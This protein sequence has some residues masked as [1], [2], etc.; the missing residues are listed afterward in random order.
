MMPNQSDPTPDNIGDSEPDS[1][2]ETP[3]EVAT[4]ADAMARKVKGG[5]E[6]TNESLRLLGAGD[7]YK[8]NNQ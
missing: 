3:E 2:P 4:P 5:M 8:C 7:S 1:G 6:D